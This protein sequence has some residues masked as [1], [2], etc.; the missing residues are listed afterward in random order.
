MNIK[1]CLFSFLLVAQ[2][3]A[4]AQVNFWHVSASAEK[5]I[6]DVGYPNMQTAWFVTGADTI[7]TY[8]FLKGKIIARKTPFDSDTTWIAND[9]I[10]HQLVSFPDKST[11]LTVYYNGR[12]KR[13]RYVVANKLKEADHW[14]HDSLGREIYHR[15]WYPSQTQT[16]TLYAN[17]ARELVISDAHS[18]VKTI[19]KQYADTNRVWSVLGKDTTSHRF[20]WEGFSE[21]FRSSPYYVAREWWDGSMRTRL[22]LAD[23]FADS[24]RTQEQND[25]RQMWTYRLED[26]SKKYVLYQYA[27]LV[28]LKQIQ[29]SYRYVASSDTARYIL[30][31][32]QVLPNNVHRKSQELCLNK[33]S[34]RYKQIDYFWKENGEIDHLE[35]TNRWGIK[36]KR[37]P[38][39][40]RQDEPLDCG[41]GR[42]D[43]NIVDIEMPNYYFSVLHKNLSKVKWNNK[44]IEQ[45]II[46]K[47]DIHG[48]RELRTWTETILFEL[49]EKALLTTIRRGPNSRLFTDNLQ[50][51]MEKTSL[52]LPPD[53]KTNFYFIDSTG[54]KHE[55]RMNYILLPA[56]IYCSLGNR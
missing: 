23:N 45:L 15:K 48:D 49:D 18:D 5:T 21:E 12:A 34:A 1:N 32:Y 16:T 29:S 44:P 13:Q 56:T 24:T 7:Y 20:F 9:S 36:R 51:A 38:D 53:V 2:T 4:F 27:K 31:T 41:T 26:N 25:I 19:R 43:Q 52:Q 33:D 42:I 8:R 22:V 11:R 37:T 39:W 46:Q 10:Y 55:K 50:H 54:K 3:I 14:Q 6:G 28:G 17:G 30:E 47:I 35:I 40:H